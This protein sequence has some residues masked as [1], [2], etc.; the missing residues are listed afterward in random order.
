MD[1]IQLVVV[2][3]FLYSSPS[4]AADE[5]RVSEGFQYSLVTYQE[6]GHD[7]AKP[8]AWT[9][10]YRQFTNENVIMDRRSSDV[11]AGIGFGVAPLF[12]TYGVFRTAT[13]HNKSTYVALGFMVDEMT[14]D[15]AATS[16][17]MSDSGLSYGIG[18]SKPSFNIEY[19]MS[20]DEGNYEISAIGLGFISEF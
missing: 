12:G 3:A 4:L 5:D 16:D 13:N 18:I 10:K 15:E 7:E 11:E 1:K 20:M 2:I 19:M 8:V 17:D 9:G 6:D 14:M